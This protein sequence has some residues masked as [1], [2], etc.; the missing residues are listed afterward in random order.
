[1]EA[2]V[3]KDISIEVEAV[4]EECGASL[5]IEES[6]RGNADIDIEVTP[7]E[8]CLEQAKQEGREEAREEMED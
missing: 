5:S 4:C 2:D 3:S 6:R 1:M 8:A 7:C